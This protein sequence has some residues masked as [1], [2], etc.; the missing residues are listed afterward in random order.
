M[1]RSVM[2]VIGLVESLALLALGSVLFAATARFD[3]LTFLPQGARDGLAMVPRSAAA[4]WALALGWGC[5]RLFALLPAWRWQEHSL[6][7]R[8]ALVEAGAA[9]T[10]SP[11][12]L[13]G[14]P[15]GRFALAALALV[16]A[17]QIL[18]VLFAHERNEPGAVLADADAVGAHTKQLWT[19]QG[20]LALGLGALLVVSAPNGPLRVAGL[21]FSR[22]GAHSWTA[23]WGMLLAGL[24]LLSWLGAG[25]QKVHVGDAPDVGWQRFAGLFALALGVAGISVIAGASHTPRPTEVVVIPFVPGV[26]TGI[27]ALA[28]AGANAALLLDP[29]WMRSRV[30]WVRDHIQVIWVAQFACFVALGLVWLFGAAAIA[31]NLGDEHVPIAR[32]RVL[33]SLGVDAVVVLG[34]MV[35]GMASVTLHGLTLGDDDLRRYFARA[36]SVWHL[37]WLAIVFYNMSGHAYRMPTRYTLAGV[38]GAVPVVLFGVPNLIASIAPTVTLRAIVHRGDADTRPA[39]L[40]TIWTVQ[41]L[42]A[43][44]CAVM[45]SACPE[46]VARVMV[47]AHS[48]FDPPAMWEVDQLRIHASYYFFLAALTWQVMNDVSPWLWRAVARV[49]VV[50]SALSLLSYAVT[51]NLITYSPI[52]LFFNVLHVAVL[53]LNLWLLR[54]EVDVEDL[55]V[56]RETPGLGNGDLVAAAPMAV[57]TVMKRRRASHLYGVG[58]EGVLAVTA[59]E[60][61]DATFPHNSYLHRIRRRKEPVTMRF[62]N[63]THEDDAALDV[64]G[65]ALRIGAEDDPERLELVFNTGSYSPPRNLVEFARFVVSKWAPKFVARFVLQHDPIVFEGAVAGLRRA[66][67]SYASLHYY[68]QIVRIWVGV[69]GAEAEADGTLRG[70]R[71]MNLVRYRLVPVAEGPESGLPDQTDTAA[72]WERGRRP[73]ETRPQDYLRRGFKETLAEGH[74][75]HFRLQAQFRVVD[76]PAGCTGEALSWYNAGVDW[77]EDRC[78]WRD[79]GRIELTRALDDARTELLRFNPGQ[80]PIDSMGVPAA[81]SPWDYRSLGDAEVRVMRLMGALR[82]LSQRWG[83]PA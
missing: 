21:T 40:I 37:T 5:A 23:L 77:D 48:P 9:A 59:P 65:A 82:A 32:V 54:H 52:L 6:I 53:L 10:L 22:A 42:A 68:A 36:L 27:L 24:G 18:F 56:A 20:F 15:R 14:G 78:P 8:F 62:A 76:E 39:R 70:E 69:P 83:G 73:S 51:F 31:G 17:V 63:L 74:D 34:A 67:E 71:Q 66:P 35:L 43:L 28:F 75:V 3:A 30:E 2:R 41:A 16:A 4:G 60:L 55:G 12:L 50:W 38:G 46:F 11:T 7:L 33:H 58:A 47:S 1:M 13:A 19:A 61:D 79:L 80:H 57:Q 64:R 25:P 44:F 45:L 81:H 72:L 26:G 49:F 29:N